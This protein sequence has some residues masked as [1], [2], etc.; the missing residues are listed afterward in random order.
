MFSMYNYAKQ[1]FSC[2]I[3][4]QVLYS[5]HRLLLL[6]PVARTWAKTVRRIRPLLLLLVLPQQF[7]P[8]TRLLVNLGLF[9]GKGLFDGALCSLRIPR[10][11]L[12]SRAP[13]GPF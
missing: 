2:S 6:Y 5:R 13:D 7:G 12:Y 4:L 3:Y 9:S 8:H 1:L 10:F 11:R